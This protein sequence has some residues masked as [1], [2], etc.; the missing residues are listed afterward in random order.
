MYPISSNT[1]HLSEASEADRVSPKR[2]L[3][4]QRRTLFVALFNSLNLRLWN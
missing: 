2:L 3:V 1:T 4:K